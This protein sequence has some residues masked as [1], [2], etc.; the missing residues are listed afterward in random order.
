MALD[1]PVCSLLRLA[2]L[3][4]SVEVGASPIRLLA[5]ANWEGELLVLDPVID[6]PGCNA[7]FLSYVF[8]IKEVV[9]A[10]S[11]G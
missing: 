1:G 2:L 4:I 8:D 10:A 11:N 6:G 3:D 9:H 5:K 7:E